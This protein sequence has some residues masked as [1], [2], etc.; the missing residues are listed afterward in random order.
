ML[1]KFTYPII[2]I[3]TS[4]FLY[5]CSTALMSKQQISY[6]SSEANKPIY[7]EGGENCEIK[8]SRAIM[9]ISQYSHWKIRVQ[10]DSLITTEG[11]FDTVHA[12]YQVQK[13]PLGN[14]KYS[15]DMSLG[16][17]NPFGCVPS[18][19]ELKA[20]FVQ[21]VN[22]YDSQST[23]S[24]S[25]ASSNENVELETD[26]K[27]DDNKSTDTSDDLGCGPGQILVFSPGD[28]LGK[29]VN[30]DEYFGK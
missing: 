4:I 5:G 7:C 1:H 28:T 20:S 22:A 14:N 30:K 2:L 18:T 8:W 11:P 26:I 13:V 15:I 6:L 16:C 23:N 3:S 25:D 9:W 10:S 27:K 29:C 19:L 17:G 24:S 21:F 12:A